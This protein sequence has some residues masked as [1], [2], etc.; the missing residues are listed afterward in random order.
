[1]TKEKMKKIIKKVLLRIYEGEED[2][3]K[4]IDKIK[5][6]SN[7]KTDSKTIK[8]IIDEFKIS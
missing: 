3:V 6:F 2:T 5:K 1:M 7:E 4:K 8:K